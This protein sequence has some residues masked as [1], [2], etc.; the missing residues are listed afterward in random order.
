MEITDAHHILYLDLISPFRFQCDS[1]E[2]MGGSE[3]AFQ[4]DEE[5]ENGFEHNKLQRSSE[6][7]APQR[8]QGR[9]DPTQDP[10][11]VAADS[12]VS[13]DKAKQWLGIV[14]D[15]GLEAT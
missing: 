13:P 11:M 2:E 6:N 3:D 12:S 5:A 4:G 14:Q 9:K 10:G 1:E 8:D 7:R 15:T